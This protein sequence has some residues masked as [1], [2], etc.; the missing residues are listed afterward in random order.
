MHEIEYDWL[1][2]S[3]QRRLTQQ[4][5]LLI[6]LHHQPLISRFQKRFGEVDQLI[7]WIQKS[8]VVQLMCMCKVESVLNWIRSQGNAY[9]LVLSSKLG[10]KSRKCIFLGFEKVLKASPIGS[11]KPNME[12]KHT[13]KPLQQPIHLQFFFRFATVALLTWRAL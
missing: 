7:I 10:S 8:L 5:S 1:R 12:S 11:L 6:D 2:C 3:Q 4:A 13:K 9:F